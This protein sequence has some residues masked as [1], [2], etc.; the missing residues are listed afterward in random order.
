MHMQM[1]EAHLS[2]VGRAPHLPSSR[3]AMEVYRGDDETI[4][5]AD[6][7][8]DDVELNTQLDAH[9]AMEKKLG[10]QSMSMK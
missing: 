2:Q 7:F 8:G 4:D 3:I 9:L 5:F 6:V 10:I 1:M